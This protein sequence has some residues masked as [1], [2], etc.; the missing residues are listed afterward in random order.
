MNELINYK[1]N[2]IT[3]QHVQIF[4]LAAHYENLTETGKRIHMSQASIS[5]TIATIEESIGV[6]LFHRQKKRIYLTDA[7]KQLAKD[8]HGILKSITNSI[9]HARKTQEEVSTDLLIADYYTSNSLIYLLPFIEQLEIK[10]PAINIRVEKTDPYTIFTGLKER[11]YDAAFFSAD[12][13]SMLR[14]AGLEYMNLFSLVPSIVFSNKHRLAAEPELSTEDFIN[15]T[16]VA[17]TDERYKFYWDMVEKVYSQYGFK[18]DIKYVSNAHS[19]A[20]E[21]MRGRTIAIMDEVYKPFSGGAEFCFHRLLEGDAFLGYGLAWSPDNENPM[22]K[23]TL[24]FARKSF[25]PRLK[26]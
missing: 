11:Y 5:R 1:L 21:L 7:G 25:R 8:W 15:E 20:F 23:N 26:E 6:K 22:L 16:I 10:I 24:A 14:S 2:G 12:G 19:M 3:L 17:M 4:C 13:E 18:S 9:E